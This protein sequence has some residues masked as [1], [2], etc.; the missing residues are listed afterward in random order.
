MRYHFMHDDHY[1]GRLTQEIRKAEEEAIELFRQ[2]PYGVFFVRD[3]HNR[4]VGAVHGQG[5]EN[6]D[7]TIRELNEFINSMIEAQKGMYI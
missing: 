3:E 2:D 7:N 4:E 6:L 5:K 1:F